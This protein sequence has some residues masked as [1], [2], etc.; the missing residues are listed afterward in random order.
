VL[1]L[2]KLNVHI[3]DHVISQIIADIQALEV[4]V[5]AELVKEVLIE[6]FEVVLD[7]ARVEIGLGLRVQGRSR[8]QHVRSL[9]HVGEKKGWADGGLGVKPRAAVAMSAGS[10]LEVEGAVHPV[11]LGTEYRSQVLRHLNLILR[12][13]SFLIIDSFWWVIIRPRIL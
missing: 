3:T 10:D 12:L 1:F 7:M 5:L 11:F 2:S 6:V 13:R 9:V 4:T 8:S